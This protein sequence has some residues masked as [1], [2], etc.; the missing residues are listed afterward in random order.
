MANHP[1]PAPSGAER[2][3]QPLLCGAARVLELSDQ[4]LASGHV[5]AL[6]EGDEQLF[7]TVEMLG[8]QDRIGARFIKG[9]HQGAHLV[10]DADID[11]AL[12]HP[13]HLTAEQRRLVAEDR[14]S[15][16]TNTSNQ[17]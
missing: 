4:F 6:T 11:A 2:A 9:L 8:V 15:T 10:A 16:R 3:A 17:C 1:V 13:G 5:V 12:E 14:K 7:T